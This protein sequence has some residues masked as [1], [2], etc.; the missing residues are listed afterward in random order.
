MKK[1]LK[2]IFSLVLVV[3]WMLLIY[4]FSDQPGSLSGTISNSIIYDFFDYIFELFKINKDNLEKF[5]LIIH[6]PIREIMHLL[7]YLILGILIINFLNL[8]E[9][10]ENIFIISILICFIYS[11]TDEIHQLFIIGRTFQYFD[12]LM[13]NIGSIIGSYLYKKFI[14]DKKIAH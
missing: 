2:K 8:I 1:N 9:I 10:K 11:V 3:I 5:V 6:E 12:I 4:Y 7:E 14:L 13:D